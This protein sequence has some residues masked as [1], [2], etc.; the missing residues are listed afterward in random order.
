M[1][2]RVEQQLKRCVAISMDGDESTAKFKQGI[3]PKIELSL[4]S[5]HRCVRAGLCLFLLDAAQLFKIPLRACSRKTRKHDT[6]SD[7]GKKMTKVVGL[8]QFG[9]DPAEFADW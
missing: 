4:E 8:E 9:I 2:K 6:S 3:D 7:S 1:G 5:R